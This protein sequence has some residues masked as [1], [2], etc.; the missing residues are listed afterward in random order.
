MCGVVLLNTTAVNIN[1]LS[2]LN[3]N[4]NLDRGEMGVYA[5]LIT[6]YIIFLQKIDS[7][8][9]AVS[10]LKKFSQLCNGTYRAPLPPQPKPQH[11]PNI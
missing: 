8:D 2:H 4:Q 10:L 6:G 11:N 5:H 3:I 7:F 1:Q 9:D